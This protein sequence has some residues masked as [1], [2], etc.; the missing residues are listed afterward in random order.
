MHFLNIRERLATG[1]AAFGTLSLIPEPA[2]LEIT[3]NLGYDF[4]IIDTEHTASDGRLV[5]ELVRAGSGAGLSPLVRTRHLDEKELLWTL[6]CGAG[7]IVLPLLEEPEAAARFAR[8]CRYPPDGDRTV[9]S[10]T[11][12]ASWGARRGDFTDYIDEANSGILTVGLIETPMG[13]ER[14]DELVKEDV[15]VFFMGRADLAMKMGLHYAPEHPDVAI[16]TEK[17]MHA[18]MAAGKVAGVLTYSVEDAHRWLEFGCRFI[19]F[20]QPEFILANAYQ[21][22]LQS[23]RGHSAEVDRNAGNAG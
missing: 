4:F 16:A 22:A 15:D 1:E 8:M 21:T 23:L 14:I 5:E 11:R 12:A 18:V 13:V 10:G 2:L 6:D 9:C 3:G 7:G 17:V 19:V 20:N